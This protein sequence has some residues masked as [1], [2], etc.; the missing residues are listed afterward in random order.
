MLAYYPLEH[1]YYLLAHDIIPATFA[2]HTLASLIPFVASKPSGK[3]V[4][5]NKGAFAIWSCRF[6]AAYIIL[7]FV[8]MKEDFNLLKLREKA[9]NK[10]KVRV[11]PGS[12]PQPHFSSLAGHH[13]PYGEG[14]A[15]QAMGRVLGRTCGQL[16]IPTSSASLVRAAFPASFFSVSAFFRPFGRERAAPLFVPVVQRSV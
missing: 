5:L 2:L 6:W 10:S 16:G 8:H 15:P 1:I 9:V 12:E 11:S 3:F 4:T 14:G 7:Q 13:L